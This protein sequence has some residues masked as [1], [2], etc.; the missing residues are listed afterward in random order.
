MNAAEISTIL[1]IAGTIVSLAEKYGPEIYETIINA[2][3]QTR[4]GTG[5]TIAEIQKIFEKCK[6]DNETI[7]NI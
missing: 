3:K 6:I 2:I 1:S 4:S 5:P 7:Q